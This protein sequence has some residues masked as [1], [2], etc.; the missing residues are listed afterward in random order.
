MY[1]IAVH[2]IYIR[3]VNKQDPQQ[4]RQHISFNIMRYLFVF[5]YEMEYVNEP[6]VRP[7]IMHTLRV[8]VSVCSFSIRNHSSTSIFRLEFLDFHDYVHPRCD[9]TFCLDSLDYSARQLKCQRNQYDAKNV[10]EYMKFTKIN[11]K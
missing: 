3:S 6:C 7:S 8:T 10:H 1:S 11:I 5:I 9:Y 2:I 4:L